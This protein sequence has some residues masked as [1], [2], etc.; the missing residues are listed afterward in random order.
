[1]PSG[2]LV[3]T[4]HVD[5]A[6][7]VVTRATVPRT[8]VAFRAGLNSYGVRDCPNDINDQVSAIGA[9]DPIEPAISPR[10]A[11]SIMAI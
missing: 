5:N 1:V 6:P 8:P 11:N 4:L 2:F 3:S 7:T 10:T 9:V